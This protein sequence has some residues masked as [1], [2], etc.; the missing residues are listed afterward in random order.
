MS[1]TVTRRLGVFAHYDSDGNVREYIRFHLRALRPLCE[2]LVFVSTAPLSEETKSKIAP[3]VDAV[4][5]LPNVGFDFW[6]WRHALGLETGLGA[7]FDEVLLTNSSVF[8]PVGDLAET[9]G[10]MTA[11]PCDYWGINES[12]E[13]EQR[14]FQSYFLVFKNTVLKSSSWSGFWAGVV[15]LADKNQVIRRYEMGIS[16]HMRN[17]GWRSA[18]VVPILRGQGTGNPTFHLTEEL[19][20]NGGHYAKVAVMRMHPPH[21][22]H[23]IVS[24]MSE[25]GYAPSMI[26]EVV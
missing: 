15:P 8:G 3:L 1:N 6:M 12:D 19:L 16:V 21:R 24:Q 18:S 2:R 22:R 11:T 17:A 7:S 20:R 25:A 14:C 5:C 4:H 9:V 10:R 23:A 13:L 26:L